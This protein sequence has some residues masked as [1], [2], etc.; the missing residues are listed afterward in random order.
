M[1][2]LGKIEFSDRHNVSGGCVKKASFLKAI[3]FSSLLLL[4][5]AARGGNEIPK[6]AW[7]RPLGLPLENPGVKRGATDIDD[8]YWQG[9][10]VGGFGSGTFSRT[11]RGDFARW[12]IKAGVHKY[13]T[14]YANQFA[15]FQQP[16]TGSQGTV[17]H[18]MPHHLHSTQLPRCHS[19]YPAR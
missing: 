16:E 12:H 7:K 9:A 3:V 5:P 19:H 4:A 14:P 1:P 11:Y 8:G 13:E 2:L 15:M 18:L 17:Q 6:A 10:P